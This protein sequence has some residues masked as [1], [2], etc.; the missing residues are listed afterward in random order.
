MRRCLLG[1]A[2]NTASRMESYSK[3][4]MVH[5]GDTTAELLAGDP[6][7]V[8][9]PRGTLEIKVRVGWVFLLVRWSERA[10]KW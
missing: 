9:Q 2:V 4:G 10:R 3:P 5:V 1:D 8:V 6:A 7:F